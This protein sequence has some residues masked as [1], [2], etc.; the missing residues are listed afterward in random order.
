M[1]DT[2]INAAL[3]S[4]AGMPGVLAQIAAEEAEA[5]KIQAEIDSPGSKETEEELAMI[6]SLRE[7]VEKIKQ[8]KLNAKKQQA[9]KSA[10]EQDPGN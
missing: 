3:S 8:S 2:S 10:D 7:Y 9:C 1:G 6:E 5:D 4:G